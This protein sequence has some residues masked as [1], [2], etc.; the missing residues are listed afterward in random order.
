MHA[1]RSAIREGRVALPQLG[2]VL[3][4]GRSFPP[5]V[6]TDAAG[7]EVAVVSGYLQDLA[8]SDVSPLTGRSYA[9]DLLRWF[10]LLWLLEVQWERATTSE[11][12]LLV[13]WMRTA[14]NVQ[15]T[16]TG[17]SDSAAPAANVRTGKPLL[18]GGYAPRTINHALSVVSGFYE[19]HLRYGRG[20]LVNP[21]PAAGWRSRPLIGRP[22]GGRRGR[23]RQRVPR[24]SP[25]AIP[26]PLWDELLATVGCD[27]DRAL[28]LVCVSSGVRASELIG[29]TVGDVDWARQVIT[30]V[31]KGSRARQSVPVSPEALRLLAQYLSQAGPTKAG[32]P[33]WRTR[34]GQQ[35]PLTYW[36]VRRVL[37]RANEKLGTNWTL[38]DLRHTA[39]TRLATDPAVTL[40]EVQTV[41]RHADISTTAL[42]TQLSVDQMFDK[43]QHHYQRPVPAP[44]PAAG[45]DPDDLRAVF[46]G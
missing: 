41:L 17:S 19:H 14:T 45:Y 5:W 2:A 16:R 43:L 36:A 9:F 24:Q 37:Q 3:P 39:A 12:A 42:Y 23:M 6:V 7:V 32:E 15:R 40:P 35:R 30:V 10:R 27:R 8:L 11:V 44:R 4:S 1:E 34:R 20:P 25:R 22:T 18:A 38:H 46:G 33:L 29:M 21:V 31:S 28:L 13:G 26:D